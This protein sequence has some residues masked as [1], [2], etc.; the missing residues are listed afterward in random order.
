MLSSKLVSIL[1]FLLITLPILILILAIIYFSINNVD[2]SATNSRD[3]EKDEKKYVFLCNKWE[4][5][6]NKCHRGIYNDGKCNKDIIDN[7]PKDFYYVS[8]FII[9]GNIFFSM[10]KINCN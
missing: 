6:E 2:E 8:A 9:L 3:C 10:L 5:M 7:I 1:L 4:V